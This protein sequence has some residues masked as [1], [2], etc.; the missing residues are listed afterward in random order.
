[1]LILSPLPFAFALLAISLGFA[2]IYLFLSMFLFPISGLSLLAKISATTRCC[3][4]TVRIEPSLPIESAA[5]ELDRLEAAMEGVIFY[6]LIYNILTN[7]LN[8]II[9]SDL[10]K[11]PS[12][13][14]KIYK[15][16]NPDL[17]KL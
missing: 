14:L 1:M 12:V 10:A 17:N 9:L 6:N 11:V 5:R 2:V 7:L 3:L 4:E 13:L 15:I 16:C 8:F